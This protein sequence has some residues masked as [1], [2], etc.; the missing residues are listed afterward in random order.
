MTSLWLSE[1]FSALL[2]ACSS[3]GESLQPRNRRGEGRRAVEQC[4]SI[5]QCTGFS[6]LMVFSR[7]TK[8]GKCAHKVGFGACSFAALCELRDAEWC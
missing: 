1:E 8:W 5:L 2:I 3:A 7:N 6:L 4:H